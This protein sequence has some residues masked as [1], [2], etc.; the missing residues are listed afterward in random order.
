MCSIVI[1]E[2]RLE[3]CADDSDSYDLSA[4]LHT[5]RKFDYSAIVRPGAGGG[6]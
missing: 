3:T 1:T 6:G 5:C 2:G 4:Q